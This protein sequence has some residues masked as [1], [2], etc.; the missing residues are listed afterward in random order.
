MSRKVMIYLMLV[1]TALLGFWQS[2]ATPARAQQE[3]LDSALAQAA[4]K[5]FLVSL[6]RPE[7]SSVRSFY[8]L[9]GVNVEGMVAGL[10]GVTGYQIVESGWVKEG[11]YQVTATLQPGNQSIKIF[12]GKYDGRWRVE[13]VELNDG[14]AAAVTN[15][16]A[17]ATASSGVRPVEGN[18]QGTL[19]FQ[20]R[21]G[22]DV[23][24]INADG[25][26]LSL[27]TRNAIDPQLSPDGARIAFT[28][29]EP[30][31][32]LFTVNLDG[33]NERAWTHGWRQMKSPTW[34][35]DGSQI[36]FSYQEG[37][38][39]NAEQVRE[40][41]SDINQD[42]GGV[43]IPHDARG[44]EVEDGILK[45]TIP[46]DAFW[47]LRSINL[48]TGEMQDL[49]TE[50]HAYGPT[51]HPTQPKVVAYKGVQGI[52]LNNLETRTDRPVTTDFRDHTPVISPDGT[53]V[54]VSYWQ[55]GHWEIHTLNIDGSNR[56]RLTTTPIRVIAESTLLKQE[57]VQGK[58]RVVVPENPWWN[59]AAPVWS[60]DGSQIAFVT[61]RA[62]RWE[63][64]VMNA[65]GAN[66]RPMFS[67]GALAGID[68]QYDG[69]DE[70][71]LSW[72]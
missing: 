35:A 20:T 10:A 11:T 32:E 5:G 62:G 54:A 14:P 45:Y 29:W 33:T 57:N 51:A 24:K 31:Y 66:Q 25:T 22:G 34:T 55:D 52:A 71:M 13:G 58:E 12:T 27:V 50:R 16:A 53:K 60:P 21:N 8:V 37:G 47:W 9:D 36:I 44:I 41:L 39:L 56:Q 43:N 7:L 59:N 18:G 19:I 65:D 49:A 72:Q 2:S 4:A 42:E 15:P 23:Y 63:I 1:L 69:V 64:W 26:G 17:P 6:I 30:R 38:R 67:N 46:A 40:D 28:R 3:T 70:R 68:L 48:N 61:D